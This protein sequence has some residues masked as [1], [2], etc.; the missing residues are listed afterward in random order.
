V[1]LCLHL[2]GMAKNNCASTFADTGDSFGGTS[3][4][5]CVEFSPQFFVLEVHQ[6]V[7]HF[8]ELSCG[9]VKEDVEHVGRELLLHRVEGLEQS[10]CHLTI[11]KDT[12]QNSLLS[13]CL[14]LGLTVGVACR[15]LFSLS[16]V[17]RSAI[18]CDCQ[19][20]LGGGDGAC[21]LI[22]LSVGVTGTGTCMWLICEIGGVLS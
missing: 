3:E 4:L 9:F 13:D 14:G 15:N 5:L 1:T 8:H 2:L 21:F 16:R 18:R 20:F 11:H 19:S 17:P 7:P 12:C 22:W 6:L 10:V